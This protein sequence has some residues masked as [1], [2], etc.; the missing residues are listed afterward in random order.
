VGRGGRLF[1]VS[2]GVT[3]VFSLYLAADN[4][5][6]RDEASFSGDGGRRAAGRAVSGVGGGRGSKGIKR[7][8]RAAYG[9]ERAARRAWRQHGDRRDVAA[10]MTMATRLVGGN[11]GVPRRRACRNADEGKTA[12]AARKRALTVTRD[13]ATYGVSRARCATALPR[14]H[15]YLAF[16][17]QRPSRAVTSCNGVE[18]SRIFSSSSTRR[19]PRVRQRWRG[20]L[21]TVDIS[22]RRGRGHATT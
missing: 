16:G 4:Q 15:N 6:H 22:L 14:L 9:D 20:A 2:G 21:R 8:H 13:N 17:G 5:A 10:E 11:S 7:Q 3:V 12:C 18:L 19:I 1:N